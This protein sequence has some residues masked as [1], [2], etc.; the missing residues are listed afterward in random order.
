MHLQGHKT[1]GML[2][3]AFLSGSP[4]LAPSLYLYLLLCLLSLFMPL[5]SISLLCLSLSLPLPL[6]NPLLTLTLAAPWSAMSLF[7]R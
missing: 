5:L 7:M 4:S 2:K 3:L 6:L 1:C